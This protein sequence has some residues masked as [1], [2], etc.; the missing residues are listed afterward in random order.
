MPCCIKIHYYYDLQFITAAVTYSVYQM[1]HVQ[2]LVQRFGRA[3]DL[4]WVIVKADNP[5]T[6]TWIGLY[7]Y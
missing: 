1:Y 6:I 3:V 7:C 4:L 2:I 5:G